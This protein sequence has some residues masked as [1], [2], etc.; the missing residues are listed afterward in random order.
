MIQIA[1]K[2]I[3]STVEA[4]ANLNKLLNDVTMG[5]GVAIKRRGKIIAQMIPANENILDETKEVK[6]LMRQLKAFHQKI[7]SNHGGQSQ[8]VALLREL[9][10]EA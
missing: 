10:G 7:K 8:T 6:E 9:R 2:K 1:H 3:Y 4:K 5:M